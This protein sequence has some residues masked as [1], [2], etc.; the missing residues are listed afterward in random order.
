MRRALITSVGQVRSFP[1]PQRGENLR[2]LSLPFGSR[3]SRTTEMGPCGVLKDRPS[4]Y[5]GMEFIR[6]TCGVLRDRPS[7]YDSM[8]FIRLTCGT[9]RDRPSTYGGIEL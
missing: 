8:E 6:L 1:A 3:R 2:S 4:T 7:T 9:L 5:D